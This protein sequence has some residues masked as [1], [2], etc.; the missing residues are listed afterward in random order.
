M[1]L[2]DRGENYAMTIPGKFLR[3]SGL[4]VE[5]IEDATLAETRL[6]EV[7]TD[8]LM[9]YDKD[10]REITIHLPDPPEEKPYPSKRPESL[11]HGE[12]AVISEGD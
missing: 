5:E 7:D 9:E 10:E 2:T 12:E 8:C 3:S 1:S 6:A 11:S 4:L